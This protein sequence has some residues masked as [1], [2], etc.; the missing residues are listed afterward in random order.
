MCH[1]NC[2]TKRVLDADCRLNLDSMLTGSAPVALLFNMNDMNT[3]TFATDY[4]LL[5]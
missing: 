3:F 2:R 4:M 1:P 5:L